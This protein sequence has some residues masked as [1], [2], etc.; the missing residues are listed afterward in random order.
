[1]YIETSKPGLGIPLTSTVFKD[2]SFIGLFNS[3]STASVESQSGV[4]DDCFQDDPYNDRLLFKATYLSP[5]TLI[6]HAFLQQPPTLKSIGDAASPRITDAEV[7]P[8]ASTAQLI[9]AYS[10]KSNSKGSIFLSLTLHFD[11][12][13]NSTITIRWRK[14]CESGINT[15]LSFGYLSKQKS[16]I[17][18]TKNL[19]SG[20]DS[21]VPLIVAP[22]DVSTEVYIKLLQLGA[23]QVFVAPYVTSTNPDVTSVTVRGNH[24]LGGVLNG[25]EMTSFLV[26]YECT[27]KGMSDIHLSFAIPPF[28]NKTAS[29]KKGAFVKIFSDFLS[30]LTI[31]YSSF[32]HVFYGD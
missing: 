30:Q 32:P 27:R 6:Q 16:D 7:D 20:N 26:N 17:S 19:F 1:M 15:Q 25:L 5:G 9:V 31:Q 29:W 23:Q 12:S 13:D 21:V 2:G 4:V 18:A 3:C 8:S 10:C 28:E 14:I 11:E 22:S 24:P